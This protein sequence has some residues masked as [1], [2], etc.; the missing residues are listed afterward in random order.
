[1]SLDQPLCSTSPARHGN[2]GGRLPKT[3]RDESP[4]RRAKCAHLR[5]TS[6]E[7]STSDPRMCMKTKENDSMSLDQPLCSTSPARHGNSGG[8]LPKTRRDE[9]PQRRAKC[10][11]LCATSLEKSTS[12]PR[13]SM[14]TNNNDNMSLDQTPVLDFPSAARRLAGTVPL[15]AWQQSLGDCGQVSQFQRLIN[16]PH[17]P[18]NQFARAAQADQMGTGRASWVA[19]GIVVDR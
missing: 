6:L 19:G 17:W 14:K 8:R 13:M 16:Y 7:K 2:S 3:R 5:A 1:M 4:R 15:K 18:Q 12:D 9:A 10:A 11:H